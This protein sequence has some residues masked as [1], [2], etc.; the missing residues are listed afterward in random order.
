[1]SVKPGTAAK[2]TGAVR[3]RGVRQRPWGKYAAEIRDPSKVS[4]I[5]LTTL[6][7]PLAGLVPLESEGIVQTCVCCTTQ[8]AS[9]LCCIPGF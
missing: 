6:H 3:F 5:I 1:M 2:G 7:S 8:P 4:C 9:A